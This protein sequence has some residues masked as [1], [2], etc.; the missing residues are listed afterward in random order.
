MV[1]AQEI[2]G[3]FFKYLKLRKVN[4]TIFKRAEMSRN[5]FIKRTSR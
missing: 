4:C 2:Q 3:L 1:L 5:I